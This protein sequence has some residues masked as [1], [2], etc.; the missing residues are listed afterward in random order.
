LANCDV[1]ERSVRARDLCKY[2]AIGEYL[3][4]IE[5][6]EMLT[7]E[8]IHEAM[9]NRSKLSQRGRTR[10][11][12]IRSGLLELANHFVPEQLVPYQ[13]ERLLKKW[14]RSAPVMFVE[15]VIAFEKW[16]S[17]GMLNPKLAMNLHEAQ[18]LANTSGDIRKTIKTVIRFLNWC[19]KR[20]ISSLA[21]INENTVASYKETLFW[22][23]ECSACRKRIPLDVANT[24]SCSNQGCHAINPYVKIRRLARSSVAQDI[25]KLRTFFNWAQLHDVVPDNPFP[26]HTDKFRRGPFPVTNNRGQMVEI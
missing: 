4:N 8:A 11:R 25:V 13:R 19:V 9:P 23:L 18:P 12:W 2:R 10:S 22:Q 20:D 24:K 15:H 1:E 17:E 7:W 26:Y 5:L 6:P 16:A 14:L 3:R 21:N